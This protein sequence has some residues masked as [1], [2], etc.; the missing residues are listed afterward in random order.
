M[1]LDLLTADYGFSNNFDG[2][3]APPKINRIYLRYKIYLFQ[4]FVLTVLCDRFFEMTKIWNYE[5]NITLDLNVGKNFKFF[6][7]FSNK[8]LL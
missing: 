3:I 4:F 7:Q 5:N 6:S 8:F 1:W 2:N